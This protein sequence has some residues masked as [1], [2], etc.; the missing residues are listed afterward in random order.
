MSEYRLCKDCQNILKDFDD[1]IRE[2]SCCDMF[3]NIC[4][5]TGAVTK[6]LCIRARADEN[7][8]GTEGRRFLRNDSL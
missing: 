8:C 5:V 1:K 3:Q 6:D 2:T 4:L 7:K